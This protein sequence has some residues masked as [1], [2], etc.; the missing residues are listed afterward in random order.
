MHD[1]SLAIAFAD[2]VI[3]LDSGKIAFDRFADFPKYFG[4][5]WGKVLHSKL[6]S[7]RTTEGSLAVV[8]IGLD[9]TP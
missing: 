7:F 1:I 4:R 8:P 3:G 5:F 2:R 6:L 9:K